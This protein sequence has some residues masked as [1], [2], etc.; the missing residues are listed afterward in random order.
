M[1]PRKRTGDDG[2]EV[3]GWIVSFADMVTLLLAFFVLLQAFAHERDPELFQAGQGSFRRAIEGLGLREFLDGRRPSRKRDFYMRRYPMPEAR[4]PQPV[5][6]NVSDAHKQKIRRLYARLRRQM[7]AEATDLRQHATDIEPMR[8]AFADGGLTEA[9]AAEL[10]GWALAFSQSPATAARGQS[11]CLVGL[12]RGGSWQERQVLS[13]ERAEAARTC[14]AAA[15]R[16]AGAAGRA[17]ALR[18][19]GAGSGGRWADLLGSGAE[20]AT[21]IVVVVSEES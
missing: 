16:R 10:R 5:E 13:A 6:Q 20:R 17:D 14:I 3:P 11:V 12:A 1:K 19:W 4:E 21:L 2:P 7:R 9:G 8:I 15:L 18:A